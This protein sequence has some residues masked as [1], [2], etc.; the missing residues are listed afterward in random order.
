MKRKEKSHDLEQPL[1]LS[2]I[3]TPSR[4]ETAPYCKSQKK[5]FVKTAFLQMDMTE[6]SS[7]L[8]LDGKQHGVM[9]SFLCDYLFDG[10]VLRRRHQIFNL[11]IV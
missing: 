2:L 5:P 9:L 6:S 8:L 11:M 4:H 7:V 1:T 3:L 10:F